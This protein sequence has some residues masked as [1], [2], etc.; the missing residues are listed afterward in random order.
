MAA[1]TLP[2]NAYETSEAIVL[3]APMP[4]VQPEDVSV[5]VESGTVRITA[6]CRTEARKDYLLHEWHY[7]PFERT[8]E[9]PNDFGFAGG[10][11]SLGNGQLAVRILRGR[12]DGDAD[13]GSTIEVVGKP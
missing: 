2:L 6:E 5:V 7:G 9:L 1:Q 12:A 13:A 4:A 8:F 3:V 11:A 10:D